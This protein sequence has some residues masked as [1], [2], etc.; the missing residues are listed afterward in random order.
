M[1]VGMGSLG[2]LGSAS[3]C[4]MIKVVMMITDG[5][6][7]FFVCVC[8]VLLI[9]IYTCLSHYWYFSQYFVFLR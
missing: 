6:A 8:V 1:L 3:S 4:I 9:D 7:F 2:S 5:D